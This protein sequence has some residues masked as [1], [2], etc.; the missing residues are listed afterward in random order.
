MKIVGW[1]TTLTLFLSIS[2]SRDDVSPN[3][4]RI[5]GAWRLYETIGSTGY[6]FYTTPIPANPTQSLT[7]SKSGQLI[8]QGE[9]IPGLFDVCCY[10]LAHTEEGMKLLLMKS[11]RDK[12]GTIVHFQVRGDTL[13]IMPTC[14]E[15]C[16]YKF[17]RLN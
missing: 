9:S 7:F 3:S 13:Q 2:C 11:K 16:Q 1:F 17:I 4:S 15:K 6:S 10:R 8:K 14:R 12:N 5:Q